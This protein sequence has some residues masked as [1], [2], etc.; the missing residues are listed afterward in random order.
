M[1]SH[2]RETS[3]SFP[4]LQQV[5]WAH[6]DNQGLHA[7]VSAIVR[8]HSALAAGGTIDRE[9][10]HIQ[11]QLAAV[12]AAAGKAGAAGLSDELLT[13]LPTCQCDQA[14][15]NS[16]AEQHTTCAICHEDFA[17]G[18]VLRRLPCQHLYHASCVG[19]W[20]RIKAAC[21]LCNAKVRPSRD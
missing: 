8:I 15:L 2:L 13:K 14:L 9:A 10:L 4:T 16:L 21:P 18:E 11:Q 19:H 1:L 12:Y 5:D 20:L 3:A 6:L 17:E 7:A